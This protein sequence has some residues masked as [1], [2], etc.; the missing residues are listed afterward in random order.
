ME[1]EYNFANGERRKFY[2]NDVRINLSVYL[3]VEH[4]NLDKEREFLK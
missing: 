3:E 2:K 4:Y 1:K